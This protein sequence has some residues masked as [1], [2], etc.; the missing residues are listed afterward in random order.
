MIEKNQE[1]VLSHAKNI[2]SGEENLFFLGHFCKGFSERCIETPWAAHHL[3]GVQSIL[4]IGFTFA[5]AEYLGLL[6]EL[7]D[8]YGVM[9]KAVDIIRPDE[10]T[11]RYPMEWLKSILEVPVKIVNVMN[12]DFPKVRFDAVSI[13]STI[14]HIGFDEPAKTVKCSSF[15]RNIDPDKV[16]L[17][18]D[19]NTNRVV[20][21]NLS[22][23][24]K[25]NGKLLLSVP[26]GKG[27]VVILRDSLGLYT[28]Q[29]EYDEE[30]W[31]EIV[32]HEKFNLL[33]ERFFK[34]T[35]DGWIEVFSP[36]DLKENSSYLKPHAE[37][38]ALCVLIKK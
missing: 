4:D 19:P 38:V 37:G 23:V 5:S 33:E 7:K 8:K 32:C 6:L 31:K 14:E 15:E 34:L 28:A 22:K 29:C 3:K 21:D 1:E 35:H 20:L 16:S 10:V 9:L 25:N 26:M 12:I 27:G 11:T 13:I 24:I 17:K 36:N 30:S 18:R 2:L